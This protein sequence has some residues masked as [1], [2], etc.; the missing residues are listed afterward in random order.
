MWSCDDTAESG[1]KTR[2]S[3]LPAEHMWAWHWT[4]GPGL[5]WG[6]PVKARLLQLLLWSLHIR[7]CSPAGQNRETRRWWRGG[8]EKEWEPERGW[9]MS[10]KEGKGRIKKTRPP[11]VASYDF[12]C[13]R[14]IKLRLSQ[15]RLENYHGTE[16]QTWYLTVLLRP[17]STWSKGP[18][19]DSPPLSP[20]LALPVVHRMAG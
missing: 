11:T 6:A 7:P 1:Q 4:L 3:V 20:A 16:T 18:R 9:L 8:A 10:D 5:A 12:A 17:T 19:D 15:R 14:E 13:L 2:I